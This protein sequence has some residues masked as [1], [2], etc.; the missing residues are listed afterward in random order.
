M[1]VLKAD[2]LLIETNN[3]GSEGPHVLAISTANMEPHCQNTLQPLT[4]VS[5]QG[6]QN[7]KRSKIQQ[8]FQSLRNC[9][10]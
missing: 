9:R 1:I 2:H 4:P 10:M 3:L 8:L 7:T 5:Y 6:F